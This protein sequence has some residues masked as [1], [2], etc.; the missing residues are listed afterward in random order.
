MGIPKNK[1]ELLTIIQERLAKLE[2][3][4]NMKL[5]DDFKY[6]F[7]IGYIDMIEYAHEEMGSEE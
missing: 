4:E 3:D 6:G 5:S 1:A 2:K 7:T